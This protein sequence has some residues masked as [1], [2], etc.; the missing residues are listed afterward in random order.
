MLNKY[1]EYLRD[2]TELSENTVNS[3]KYDI[4]GFLSY[5]KNLGLNEPTN[6]AVMSYIVY[7]NTQGKSPATVMRCIS[8]VKKFGKYMTEQGVIDQDICAGI[9]LPKTESKNSVGRAGES[10]ISKLLSS[11]N[12]NSIKGMR[13]YAMICLVA[14]SGIQ[15]SEITELDLSNFNGYG[16]MI[17]VTKKGCNQFYPLSEDVCRAIERYVKFCR[18]LIISDNETSLFVNTNG[19]R[20]T[21]QGFWKIIRMYK[22]K[23]SIKSCVT[24][25]S[26]RY[27]LPG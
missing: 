16:M 25:R 24:P 18:P 13:D 7:M 1:V 19:K 9:K 12:Q 2:N 4:D 23:A 6:S 20:M 26:I 22:E 3:Y 21:R 17:E 14:S 10:D 27:S 5:C 8:A 15:A 11:I